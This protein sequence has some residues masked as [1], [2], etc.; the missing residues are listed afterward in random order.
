MDGCFWNKKLGF[1]C[2]EGARQGACLR[3]TYFRL[4]CEAIGSSIFKSVVCET[5]TT[6]EGWRINSQTSQRQR[7]ATKFCPTAMYVAYGMY[8]GDRCGT[9]VEGRGGVWR[10]VLWGKRKEVAS[11]VV[12]RL[13]CEVVS[14]LRL[15]YSICSQSSLGNRFARGRFDRGKVVQSSKSKQ[16]DKKGQEGKERLAKGGKRN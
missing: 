16:K 1:P 6:V 10:V 9:L 8:F 14:G 11:Q 12:S 13:V 7:G 15:P 5:Y 3:L 4:R 2:W